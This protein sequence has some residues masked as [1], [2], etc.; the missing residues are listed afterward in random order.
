MT[1]IYRIGSLHSSNAEFYT[2]NELNWTHDPIKVLGV[3][4]MHTSSDALDLNY[5][6]LIDKIK[7]I[8]QVWKQCSLSL[9]GKVQIVNSL[10]ASLFVYK[11]E[12][13]PK[14]LEKVVTE[15]EAVISNFLW[16]GHK[17]KIPLIH[18]QKDKGSGGLQ[19]CNL[20]WQD[21]AIKTKWIKILE[22]NPT[23]AELIYKIYKLPLKAKTWR[24]NLAEQ[25]V[26]VLSLEGFWKDVAEAWFGHK[27][28]G[29]HDRSFLWYDSD[30]RIGN[31]PFC[32]ENAFLRGLEKVE[33][34]YSGSNLTYALVICER[35][36]MTLMQ[37][38]SLISAIPKWLKP[39]QAVEQC[40]EAFELTA[41]MVYK[42]LLDNTDHIMTKVHALENDL[43]EEVSVNSLMEAFTALY[44][45]TNVPK[46]RSFQ[47]RLLH[48]A[49]IMNTHLMHWKLTT[50]DACTFCGVSRE[51]YAHVFVQCDMVKDLWLKL[52]ELMNKLSTDLIVF[53]V[54]NSLIEENP[55]HLK[56]FLCL[57]MK[58]YI[59]RQRCLKQALCFRELE[60]LIWTVR[61]MEQYI[62][63]KNNRVKTFN[64]KWGFCT[65]GDNRETL[66]GNLNDYIAEYNLNV[67]IR[68]QS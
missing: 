34:L 5:S 62:A 12:L 56:N 58:Q 35:Y 18:L 41:R 29:K 28:N 60:A 59:Y 46:Y 44:R 65:A 11:M 30:I 27:N 20:Q 66:Q 7:G 24:C 21:K 49:I 63:I 36:G 61:N 40:G 37:C 4:I 26:N 33:Q 45:V 64:R 16:N 53:S 50:S 31:K 25:D 17:P 6:P 67:E 8:L 42:T 22:T 32:W 55:L 19:L 13:L 23:F 51:T 2:Q 1:K 52:E 54:K 10:V 39:P 38:N 68:L 9:I 48:C 15:V 14:I 57:V 3:Y 47:Y 43:G